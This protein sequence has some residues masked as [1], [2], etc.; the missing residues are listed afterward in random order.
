M[1]ASE[2]CCS[3]RYHEN[4]AYIDR[5]TNRMVKNYKW[6]LLL[7][8]MQAAVPPNSILRR[9][10]RL[11]RFVDTIFKEGVARGPSV[12]KG[13]GLFSFFCN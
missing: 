9:C 5:I 6:I 3:T 8:S 11:Q 1:R 4:S 10:L 12:F 7:I 2:R 13:N